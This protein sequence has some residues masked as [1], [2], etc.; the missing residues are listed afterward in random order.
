MRKVF[1][2]TEFTGLH[3]NTTLISIGLVSGEH[4]FY[5]EFTDYDSAQIDGW[6]AGNVIS[7]LKYFGWTPFIK[8]IEGG[9]HIH[10]LGNTDAVRQEL[11]NWLNGFNRKVEIWSD[12]LSYDW[13][14]F[15]QIW[16]HAF[17]VPECVYP[18][19]FDIVTFMKLFDVDPDTSRESFSGMTDGDKHNSLWDAKVI[20]GCYNALSDIKDKWGFDF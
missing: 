3:Q 16:G 17:N 14:L 6:L 5:A 2:D 12:C 9:R 7:N 13:V 1:L 8:R 20:Q 4:E 10:M 19:P 18:Y 15:C 11:T